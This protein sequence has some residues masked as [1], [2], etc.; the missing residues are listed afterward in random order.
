[1]VGTFPFL[2]AWNVNVTPVSA[3]TTCNQEETSL[4]LVGRSLEIR[5]GG[6]EASPSSHTCLSPA[7][8]VRNAGSCSR[9]GCLFTQTF[10]S[11]FWTQG[12]TTFPICHCSSV[13]PRD[14]V[15]AN[16]LQAQ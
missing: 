6:V 5:E 4:R 11:S 1:M 8:Y 9:D 2:L 7:L 13:W 12:W 3:A 14:W 16:G 10:P 15:P